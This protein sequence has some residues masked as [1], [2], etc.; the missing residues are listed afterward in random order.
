MDWGGAHGPTV[1][2]WRQYQRHTRGCC[3]DHRPGLSLE[4]EDPRSAAAGRHRCPLDGE[5][6]H[7]L[8]Q[9]TGQEPQRLDRRAARQ[10]TVLDQAGGL[11]GG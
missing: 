11:E 5:I 9:T 3:R 10:G 4:E 7:K 2:C 6:K 1:P 8:G